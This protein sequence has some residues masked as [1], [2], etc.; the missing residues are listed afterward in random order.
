MGHLSKYRSELMGVFCLWIML[1]HSKDVISYPHWLE[2]M[3]QLFVR[4]NVG[5]DAFLMLSGIGLYY[6]YSKLRAT[7]PKVGRRL[8]QFYRR[9]FVRLFIPYLLIAAPYFAWAAWAKNAGV[10]RFLLDFFQISLPL[11]GNKVV[12][13][14]AALVLFY[15]LFP[16][17]DYVLQKPMTFRGKP[18]ERA[19]ITFL[20]Y[21]AS[22]VVC[23]F[24]MKLTPT[25][26]KNTEIL[27]TRLG[28]FILGCGLG[29]AVKHNVRLP[30]S[31]VVGSAVFMLIYIFI[32][33]PSI[34]STPLW[35]RVSE[36]PFAMASLILFAWAFAK[37]DGCAKTRKFF[38]FCGERS[39][40]LYLTHVMARR[41]W[42]FYLPNQLWDKWGALSYLCILAAS[43]VISIILHPIIQWISKKLLSI[44]GAK[45]AIA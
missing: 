44:G 1:H 15:L 38:S 36:A 16:L 19:S 13:Y 4:G 20:L 33:G 12:W 3:R 34:K 45:K 26:Y 39:L 17:F 8:S 23:A 11:E 9:R 42:W 18:V 14:M 32:F 37:L 25:F 21:L 31:A 43:F 30:S 27:L 40:E 41:V 2:P 29:S 10:K 28:V 5:V 24:F 35:V 6:A 22:V 7:E